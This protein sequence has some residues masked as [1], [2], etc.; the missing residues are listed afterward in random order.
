MTEA[1]VTEAPTESETAEAPKESETKQIRLAPLP[2]SVLNPEPTAVRTIALGPVFAQKV[3]ETNSLL[4]EFAEIREAN[5]KAA[6]ALD[7][8]DHPL[9]IE[10]RKIK[11]ATDQAVNSIENDSD[12][13]KQIK[14]LKEAIAEKVKAARAQLTEIREKAQTEVTGSIV[15]E[16]DPE[17]LSQ[18]LTDMNTVLQTMKKVLASENPDLSKWNTID[19]AKAAGKKGSRKSAKTGTRRPRLAYAFI[20][21]VEVVASGKY[22]TT[23]DVAKKLG[24]TDVGNL[25]HLMFQS[26]GNPDQIPA[27]EF[28]FTVT[29][30]NPGVDHTIR[31]AGRTAD[32]NE[33]EAAA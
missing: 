26:V 16:F 18:K 7:K 24:V 6:E 31:V 11:S 27:S 8:S 29:V 9:A 4:D 13:A 12:E 17:A 33:A 21:D 22:V 19:P 20:D 2:N 30:G 14:Q 1:A 23:S 32:A 15:S 28:H 5:A 10:Y 25:N 3:D